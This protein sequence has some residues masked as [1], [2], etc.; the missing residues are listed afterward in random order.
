M[1]VYADRVKE[2]TTTTGTG[3]YSL[4]GAATGFRTFVAGAGSTSVVTYVAENGTDWEVGEGTVTS[5][6]PDT[7][8]R[9]TILASSNG[10]SAVSWA[11]GTKNIFLTYAAARAVTVDKTNT[12]TVGQTISGGVLTLPVGAISAP[13]LT[14]SGDTDLGLYRSAA[15]SLAVSVGTSASTPALVVT[16]ENSNAVGVQI[17]GFSSGYPDIY[18]TGT[19]SNI[20]ISLSSKGTGAVRLMNGAAS[21]T[22]GYFAEYA[23]KNTYQDFRAGNG[24]TEHGHYNNTLTNANIAYHITS[25]TSTGAYHEFQSYNGTNNRT[26]FRVM[27]GATVSGA[28][29]YL[30]AY[31]AN[32]SNPPS[33]EA[34]GGDTNIHLDLWSKGSNSIRFNGTATT[35]SSAGALTTSQLVTGTGG[36]TVSAG[37]VTLSTTSAVDKT[38]SGTFTIS[39]GALTVSTTSAVSFTGAVVSS[40]KGFASAE[41]SAGNSGTSKTITWTDGQNQVLTLTGNVTLT[42]ASPTN[43]ATYKLHI[44]QGAGPY[45]ITWPTIKW[46]GGVA[47]TISTGNGNEDFVTLFYNGTSYF[48]QASLNFA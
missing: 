12:F 20:D 1:A 29:N 6:S 42:F 37:A 5:G 16:G 3:T 38:G 7:L 44:I 40:T 27:H 14:F 36:L 25:G 31:S 10:G 17:D 28:Q 18:A 22:I 8:S 15:N 13:S 11:A 41:F 35:I 34:E 32:A 2:T 24:F 39:S 30:T 26:M 23:S 33:L 43:G 4:A 48:G 9:T 21:Y 45:T 47:P 46:A 19:G